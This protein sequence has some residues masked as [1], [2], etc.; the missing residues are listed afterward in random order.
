MRILKINNK[1]YVLKF[2][3]LAIKNLNAKGVTLIKLAESMEKLDFTY[4][5]LAFYEGLKV[6]KKDLKEEEAYEILDNYF[7]EGNELESLFNI[8]LE[9]YSNSMGLGKQ[10]KKMTQQQN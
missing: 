4:F 2:T 6:A 8:V 9:E 7:E 5:Y 10:F 1:E 3:T